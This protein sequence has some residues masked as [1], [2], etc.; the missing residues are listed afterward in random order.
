MRG[1]AGIDLG[2]EPVPGETTIPRFRRLLEEHDLGRRLFAEVGRV[3][4]ERGLKVS[5]GTIVDACALAN[6]FLVRRH[7]AMQGA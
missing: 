3:L 7:P 6:L 1:F 5:G 4:Q 2:G